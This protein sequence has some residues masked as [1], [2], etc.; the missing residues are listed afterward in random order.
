MQFPKLFYFF[1]CLDPCG[2][3]TYKNIMRNINDICLVDTTYFTVFYYAKYAE[4]KNM[5]E[6]KQKKNV[7]Y[8]TLTPYGRKMREYIINIITDLK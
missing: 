3:L 6:I 1:Y 7:H 4:S 2:E 5:I 8:I